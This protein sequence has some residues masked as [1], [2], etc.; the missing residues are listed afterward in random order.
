MMERYHIS[1]VEDG[2][3]WGVLDMEADRVMR[4]HTIVSRLNHHN[5]ELSE[6]HNRLS[7]FEEEMKLANKEIRQLTTD[8]NNLT[9]RVTALE[10]ALQHIADGN[11]SPCIT[12]ARLILEGKSLEDAHHAQAALWGDYDDDTALA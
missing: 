10:E 9:A 3:S 7:V 2:N 1:L 12:F 5:L 11:L 8:R 4:L 6:C